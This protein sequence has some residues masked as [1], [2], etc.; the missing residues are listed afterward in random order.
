L[1]GIRAPSIELIGIEKRYGACRS[2][3]GVSLSVEPGTIHGIVGENGAGKST[4]M[5]ILFGMIR[6]N[7]GEIRLDGKPVQ[8]KSSQDAIRAGIG[9]VHQHFMLAEPTSVLDNILLG[10][11]P[12]RWAFLPKALR[13]VDRAGARQKLQALIEQYSPGLDLDASIESLPV[14]LQQKVEILK[15]LYRDSKVLILDEPTAVL[16]PQETQEFFGRLRELKAAGHSILIITHKL[17]EVMAITDAVTVLR[18]GKS[19][20]RFKTSETNVSQLAEAMV[21]RHM[22]LDAVAKEQRSPHQGQPILSAKNLTVNRPGE[23]RPALDGLSFEVRA[24]EIVGI[25]GVD[26]NGQSELIQS[27]M[28]ALSQGCSRQGTVTLLGSE[29]DRWPTGEIR[30][31]P[32]GWIPEDRHAEGLLLERDVTANLLLGHSRGARF[33]VGGWKA[34]RAEV[35]RVMESFDIRPRDPSLLAGRFSGG[36]QQKIVIGRELGSS[37]KFIIVAQPT[38]GV[39]VGAIERIHRE[40]LRAREQGAAIL[41]VSSEL[42]EVLALSDRVLVFYRGRIVGEQKR[43]EFDRLWIGHRMGAGSEAG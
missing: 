17:S 9:M 16:T 15:L 8:W 24:G 10:A 3:D 27:I 4:A 39:D 42:D 36:N 30:K 5:K 1:S 7:A 2:N 34:I 23:A 41:L 35:T 38:R 20:A 37:P 40:V 32:V 6:P 25:A 33:K 22:D 43:G 12:S 13:P 18:A 14:G 26:G 11:E 28:G 31:L 29:V 21:G 19:V